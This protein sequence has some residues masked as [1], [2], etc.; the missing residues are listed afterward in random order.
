MATDKSN[1]SNVS[2]SAETNNF[3]KHWIISDN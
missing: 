2:W 1:F 3:D